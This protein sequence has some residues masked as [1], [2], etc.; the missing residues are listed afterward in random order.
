MFNNNVTTKRILYKII[1]V[2]TIYLDTLPLKNVY[3]KW[4]SQ[5]QKPNNQ[6]V[7]QI[8]IF[9]IQN[10]LESGGSEGVKGARG[11]GSSGVQS[12]QR[13][14]GSQGHRGLR[15]KWPVRFKYKSDYKSCDLLKVWVCSLVENLFFQKNPLQDLLSSLNAVIST[16]KST[17]F[18][19]GQMFY[20]LDYT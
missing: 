2:K 5:T 14:K 3:R 7:C 1:E 16:N 4:T 11:P 9:S 20:N 12:D 18:I 19:A 10:D 13:V 8:V 17:R 15:D 6:R